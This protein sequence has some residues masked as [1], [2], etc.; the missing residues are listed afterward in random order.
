M[1]VRT[2]DLLYASFSAIKSKPKS[3]S[4]STYL[5]HISKEVA[6]LN[7]KIVSR[8]FVADG[9]YAFIILV[10]KP[11]EVFA[12]GP[13]TRTIHHYIEKRLRPLVEKHLSEA[14]C[15]N[16][17]GYGTKY[18]INR[19]RRLIK[20]KHPDAWIGK[21]DI[22]GYFPSALWDIAYSRLKSIILSEYTGKD[23]LDLLYLLHQCIYS[24]PASNA[25]CEVP[26]IMWTKYIDP[27]KSLFNQ[28]YGKGAAIGF[29]V[30]QLAMTYY[31]SDI[32]HWIENKYQRVGYTRFVDDLVFVGPREDIK[33]LFRGLRQKLVSLG[34][35]INEKK[36]Y[37]QPKYHGLEF[38]GYHI[39]KSRI[40][41]NRKTLGRVR[42]AIDAYN[43]L[44]DKERAADSFCC[45][46]NSYLGLINTKEGQELIS[47]IDSS[48]TLYVEIY[49][50]KVVW[51]HQKEEY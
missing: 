43:E 9:N 17:V 21:I 30:W 15:N 47:S 50:N 11:R 28:P 24:D 18:A 22:Q 41:T 44:V 4:N 25:I 37:L 27:E 51:K 16:R 20:E 40:H 5:W 48:W 42:K 8:T 39:K 6:D 2:E 19:V 29:L 10:P 36:T 23:K 34:L 14:V 49:K 13:K 33:N 32:D 1:D 26:E 7:E 31:L 12:T 38:L 46:C 3:Y 45:T 35:K